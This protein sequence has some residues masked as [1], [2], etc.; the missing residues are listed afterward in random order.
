MH[1]LVCGF[2]KSFGCGTITVMHQVG[3]DHPG[4]TGST[5]HLRR[6]FY[7]LLLFPWIKAA[8]PQSNGD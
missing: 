7:F 6:R 5:D 4:G 3:G 1:G 2:G 8:P